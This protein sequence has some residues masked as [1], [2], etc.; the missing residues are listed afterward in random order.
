MPHWV[1]RF[2][3]HAIWKTLEELR[4]KLDATEQPDEEAERD[5][6]AYTR[7]I[8]ERVASY[9]K[10]NDPIGFTEPMLAGTDGAVRLLVD[11]YGD[12]QSGVSDTQQVR[13]AVDGVIQA[14][15][16]WPSPTPKQLGVA[17]TKV[18][19][20]IS[21]AS[22]EAVLKVTVKRDEMAGALDDLKTRSDELG[23]AVEDLKRG[24]GDAMSTHEQTW[25]DALDAKKV[26]AQSTMDALEKL[27]EEA[28]KV[29]HEATSFTVGA[30]Y[31]EY[32]NEKRR[33]ARMYDGAA[34][35][36]GALGLV[37]LLV[38]VW[39]RGSAESTASLSL[40]RFGITAGAL[41]IGG[42]LASRG[43]DQHREARAARRTSL[44]LSR[45][46]PFIANLPKDAREVLTVETADRIFT[47]GEL[48]D[49]SKRQSALSKLEEIREKR[50]QNGDSADVED[51]VE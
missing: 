45:M 1:E 43:A 49:V 31:A 38:Y 3:S 7:A 9:R 23:T 18:V 35:A 13:S 39:E 36:F 29:V 4:A 22:T 8:A 15:S 25:S 51:A 21:E 19:N 27:R 14:V 17:A 34:V 28:Q 32:A 50:R 30:E 46:A 11:S 42:F 37:S 5:T 6:F 10:N 44:A 16:S 33:S 12:W 2:E 26:E 24:V 40:T 20:E 48:S 47:K 41:V